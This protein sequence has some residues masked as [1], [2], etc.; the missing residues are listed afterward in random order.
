MNP[1]KIVKYVFIIF[2]F[3]IIFL[4]VIPS[5]ICQ[6]Y[7]TGIINPDDFKPSDD[8]GGTVIAEKAGG[9]VSVIRVGGIIITVLV[10]LVLGIK[11]MVGSVSEKA[12]YKK[13]M[14][15]Y[16]IGTVIFFAI[17]QF[18]SIIMEMT[19]FINE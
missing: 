13:T 2:I 18:V 15:P 10:L 7:A 3:S 5:A 12:D 19:E 16:L 11:Y 8:I 1:K 14:I 4:V 17:S 6:T 9:I